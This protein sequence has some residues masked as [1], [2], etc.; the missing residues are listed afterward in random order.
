MPEGVGMANPLAAAQ[1]FL[2]EDVADNM[3]AET[4]FNVDLPD[5]G[6]THLHVQFAWDGTPSDADNREDAVLRVTVW[7]PKSDPVAP[8]DAAQGLR[9]RL[10]LWSSADVWRVDRGAGRLPGFDRD[11]ELPFCTFTVQLVMHTA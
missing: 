6:L 7:G 3:A 8:A 9:K 1:A 2:D 4:T 5:E 10:L 11:L